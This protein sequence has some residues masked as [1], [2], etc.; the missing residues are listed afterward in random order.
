MTNAAQVKRIYRKYCHI[1]CPYIYRVQCTPDTVV[2]VADL[3]I[4]HSFQRPKLRWY[5]VSLSGYIVRAFLM[6][7]TSAAYLL[8]R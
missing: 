8:A 4:L 7:H 3:L 2:A 6:L 5:R 1:M